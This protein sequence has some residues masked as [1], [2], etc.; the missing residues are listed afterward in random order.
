MK[1]E[2]KSVTTM[3]GVQS[4]MTSGALLMLMWHADN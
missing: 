4:V 1:D 2:L 3:L